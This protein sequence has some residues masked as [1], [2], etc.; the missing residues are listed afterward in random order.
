VSV[1]IAKQPIFPSA[2]MLKMVGYQDRISPTVFTRPRLP[3]VPR[4]RLPRPTWYLRDPAKSINKKV[5]QFIQES[6]PLDQIRERVI[7][8]QGGGSS[9]QPGCSALADDGV[10]SS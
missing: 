1:P 10:T 3:T 8:A 6:A 5:R 9:A 4:H 7:P 2:E